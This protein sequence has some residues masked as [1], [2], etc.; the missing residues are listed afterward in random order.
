MYTDV[1]MKNEL[2]EGFTENVELK[3]LLVFNFFGEIINSGVQ[4]TGRCRDIKVASISGLLYPKLDDGMTPPNCEIM[5][6]S[7]FVCKMRASGGKVVRARK[8]NKTGD[9]PT[10]A[11]L[12]A[13]D[14]I[15]QRVLPSE[16]Q[17][18]ERGFRS[19]KGTFGMI[20]LPLTVVVTRCGCLPCDLIHLLNL[21]T[22]VVCLRQ[23]RN[24]YSSAGVDMAPW[25][26]RCAEKLEVVPLDGEVVEE[27]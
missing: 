22:R 26:K 21:R 18:A 16:Q 23:I 4:F 9:L 15:M 19:L 20:R 5:G 6:D 2:Y 3:N 11:A 7:D 8:F 24:T 1:D 25:I 12:T 17:S 14:L 13:I 27:E 10:S